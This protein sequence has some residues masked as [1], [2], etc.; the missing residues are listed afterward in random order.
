V[1]SDR[2]VGRRKSEGKRIKP[3]GDKIME[4][5]EI[6]MDRPLALC[7]TLAVC[8][9][10]LSVPM[11]QGCSSSGHG[12]PTPKLQS[13]RQECLGVPNCVSKE[14]DLMTIAGNGR[15]SFMASCPENANNV[16]NWDIDHSMDVSASHVE[17]NGGI[18]SLNILNHSSD[19]GMFKV[20]LGCSAQPVADN[21]T[22]V[23]RAVSASTENP[24]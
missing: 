16:W 22:I 5:W 10:M 2:R 9:V 14:E 12:E 1:I 18:L 6:A 23:F 20:F 21:R 11:L 19:T 13:T 8:L 17:E 24:E 3:N 7:G 15:T 4:T